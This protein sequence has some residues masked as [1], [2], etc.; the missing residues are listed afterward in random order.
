MF[1]EHEKDGHLKIAKWRIVC[2]DAGTRGTSNTEFENKNYVDSQTGERVPAN[3]AI[4]AQTLRKCNAC[5]DTNWRTRPN[6][7]DEYCGTCHPNYLTK[8]GKQ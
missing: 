7:N 5:G 4:P 6:G 1:I 2:G 3:P 8:G